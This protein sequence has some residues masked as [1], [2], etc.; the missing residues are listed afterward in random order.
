MSNLSLETSLKLSQTLSPQMIQSLKLLQYSNLQLEQVIRKEVQEN[1]IL[2]ELSEEEGAPETPA[3][4]GEEAT[5]PSTATDDKDEE[6]SEVETVPIK[7]LEEDDAKPVVPES[8]PIEEVNWGD[9]EGESYSLPYRKGLE[10]DDEKTSEIYEKISL[11]TVSL[12]EHLLKQL[13]EKKFSPKQMEIGEFIIG[14]V[15]DKGYLVIPVE[16][17]AQKLGVTS[18]AVNEVRS[19]IQ[20]FDPLGVASLDLRENLL[21]QCRA[22]G[23]GDRLMA[24]IIDQ[25]F[26]LL[27][28]YQ[29]PE[30]AKRLGVP[31]QE[32]Q[33]A[34]RD[35]GRLEPNP[36]TLI[37]SQK[38]QIIT[39]ELIV[40]KQ[41]DGEFLVT[42]NDGN[43]PN[44]RVS[45]PYLAL[46]KKEKKRTPEIKKYISEKLNS[47]NWLI[48][49]IEQRKVTMIKVMTAIVE[50]QREWFEKGP[51]HLAPLRLQEIADMISMHISTVC[52]VTNDKYVQ[53]PYGIFELKYFFGSGVEQ[54]DGTEVSTSRAKDLL[55]ELVTQEA[56][57]KPLSDQKL[58]EM[59]K[60]RGI[61]VARRTISKYREQLGILPARLRKEF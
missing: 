24:R 14:N 49:A 27:K 43:V 41:E 52:R 26:E 20:R 57:K 61:E 3:A 33:Q 54:Q 19:L 32:V 28:K 45:R 42:L 13:Q 51:P 2:E 5:G 37:S 12:E 4:A 7:T 44:L 10:E 46:L 47:A 50:K 39:P 40:T 11:S 25:H 48:R 22:K 31:V 55:Q 17:I 58:V 30:I 9:F 1:P 8:S 16:E 15:D 59:L 6:R 56:K 53:T 29:M 18:A 60:E 21:V 34:V 35:I 23:M 38:P 36:G